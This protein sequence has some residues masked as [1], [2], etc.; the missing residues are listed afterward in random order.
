MRLI[1]VLAFALGGCSEQG[2]IETCLA[3]D[4]YTGEGQVTEDSCICGDE[5]GED[6]S[7]WNE[8]PEGC[9]AT[10]NGSEWELADEGCEE[11]Q[12]D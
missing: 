6:N 11:V 7:S 12:R 10:C 8:L 4:T 9:V 5:V 1:W 2:A 3:G